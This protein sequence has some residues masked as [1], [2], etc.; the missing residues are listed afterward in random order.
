MAHTDVCGPFLLH[1]FPD[2]ALCLRHVLCRDPPAHALNSVASTTWRTRSTLWP[3]GSWSRNRRLRR[4]PLTP[5]TAVAHTRSSRRKSTVL[6]PP[7]FVAWKYSVSPSLHEGES[8]QCR[9]QRHRPRW[10]RWRTRRRV[11]PAPVARHRALGSAQGK[12]VAADALL[13]GCAGVYHNPAA[14][15]DQTR[16][17]SPKA[18]AS[19]I[20]K[21]ARAVLCSKP[22]GRFSKS[23]IERSCKTPDGKIYHI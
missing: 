2:A 3:T 6:C 5:V 15:C 7:S 8:G 9:R 18:S 14:P 1:R 4:T 12:R 11:W 20:C 23:S 19:G 16:C 10:T 22:A 13:V 17:R 21:T